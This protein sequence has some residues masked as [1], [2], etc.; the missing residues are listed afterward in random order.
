MKGIDF[1][2]DSRFLHKNSGRMWT[3]QYQIL[4][5]RNTQ[6]HTSTKQDIINTSSDITVMLLLPESLGKQL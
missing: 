3:F 1:L 4:H 6:L 2:L 5:Q